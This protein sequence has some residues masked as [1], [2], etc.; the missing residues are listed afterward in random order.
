[1]DSGAATILAAGIAFAGIVY[2]QARHWRET[3]RDKVREAY[4]EWMSALARVRRTEERF[5]M[6]GLLIRASLGARVAAGDPLAEQGIP[7]TT[8]VDLG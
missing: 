1:M 7:V 4:A 5:L 2:Q 8:R 6:Q 3:R